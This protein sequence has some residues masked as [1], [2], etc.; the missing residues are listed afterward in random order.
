MGGGLVKGNAIQ[1]W[2]CENSNPDQ[3]F[4]LRANI[5]TTDSATTNITDSAIGADPWSNGSFFW[6]PTNLGGNLPANT[7]MC[8]DIGGGASGGG[9][10]GTPV[11]IWPCNNQNKNQQW[12]WDP[13]GYIR[14]I[15]DPT[16]C[17]DVTGGG[18]AGTRL[19]LL[20][21]NFTNSSSQTPF[22]EGGD[23]THMHAGLGNNQQWQYINYIH[24]S[25][26][27]PY[28]THGPIPA[29]TASGANNSGSRTKEPTESDGE[30]ARRLIYHREQ[31]AKSRRL[32]GVLKGRG[33]FF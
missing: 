29:L 6:A 11:V 31:M 13:H 22:A 25:C 27:D 24:A 9:K 2:E 28:V 20:T 3:Q 18:G 4:F 23:A 8:L 17:M 7:K 32:A 10:D 5:S 15:P 33:G 21:C 26:P 16:K 1:L 30:E 12:G 19:Q 14:W